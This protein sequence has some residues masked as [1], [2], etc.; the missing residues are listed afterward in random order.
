MNDS[1]CSNGSLQAGQNV[2]DIYRPNAGNSA[3]IG[4]APGSYIGDGGFNQNYLGTAQRFDN[5]FDAT[6]QTITFEMQIVSSGR[7]DK[8][9]FTLIDDD[10]DW[11]NFFMYK[12]IISPNDTGNIKYHA[13]SI[14]PPAIPL[15]VNHVIPLLIG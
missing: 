10:G 13:Q 12:N 9:L 2:L 15:A 8:V 7:I 6:D 5:A 4:P 1:P 3:N 14:S 11:I